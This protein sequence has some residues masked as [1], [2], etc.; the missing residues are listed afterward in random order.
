VYIDG[1]S[2]NTSYID[3]SLYRYT[4]SLTGGEHSYY[5]YARREDGYSYRLPSTG[6]LTGPTVDITPPSSSIADLPSITDSLT[7]IISWS[8][9]DDLTGIELY[10]IQYKDG[11]MGSWTNWITHTTQTSA[12]F[13]GVNGHTYYFQS[14]AVDG[15]GNIESYPSGDGDAYTTIMTTNPLPTC[16][17]TTPVQG[18]TVSKTVIISGT[19]SS[20]ATKVYIGIDSGPWVR[21]TGTTSWTYNWDTNTVSNGDHVIYAKSYDGTSYSHEQSVT[22]NVQNKEDSINIF[23]DWG[24]SGVIA[25]AIVAILAIIGVV[26]LVIISKRK[27]GET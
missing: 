6:E 24:S 8:G 23:G 4:T 27:K 5:F 13:E 3:G 20:S 1:I 10:D 15:I 12:T 7:F 19:A 21:V 14:R 16:S 22:I 18:N 25:L 9:T 17:I 26:A 2:H 11:A